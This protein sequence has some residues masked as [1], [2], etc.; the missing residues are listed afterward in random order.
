MER[1]KLKL[2]VRNLKL[3][4]E[5]LESEIFSDVDSYLPDKSEN[6][7]DEV[8]G[9]PMDTSENFDEMYDDWE[10]DW[11]DTQLTYR[12]TNDDDGDGL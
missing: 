1:E 6:F 3:L 4:V 11:S 5:S 7:D 10:Y 2:I 8:S 9:L 12:D